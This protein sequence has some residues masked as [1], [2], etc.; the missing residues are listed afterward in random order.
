MTS[1]YIAD[2]VPQLGIRRCFTTTVRRLWYS[3]ALTAPAKIGGCN[4][5]DHRTPHLVCELKVTVFLSALFAHP[6]LR[7]SRSPSFLPM[8]SLVFQTNRC[9]TKHSCYS[10]S[11]LLPLC[12][13]HFPPHLP[14]PVQM[15]AFTSSAIKGSAVA[16]GSTQT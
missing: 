14:L 2:D 5:S 3:S 16:A 4:Y 15:S 9:R 6:P 1:G 8:Y 11:A 12:P 10:L 13:P 7:P